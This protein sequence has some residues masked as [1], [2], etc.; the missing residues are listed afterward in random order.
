VSQFS[1]QP[2]EAVYCSS[3]LVRLI[4]CDSNVEVTDGPPRVQ[5]T[6]QGKHSELK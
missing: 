4:G 2:M 3:K 5:S 6:D 1:F